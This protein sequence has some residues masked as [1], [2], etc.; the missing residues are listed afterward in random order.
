MCRCPKAVLKWTWFKF[1]L[2][3]DMKQSNYDCFITS[4]C[5]CLSFYLISYFF[6]IFCVTDGK[7]VDDRECI[8][9]Q[10]YLNAFSIKNRFY[11]ELN[12]NKR[13]K[14]KYHSLSLFNYNLRLLIIWN[15]HG[16]ACVNVTSL[17]SRHF[18]KKK[19]IKKTITKK[20]WSQKKTI[21]FYSI[22]YFI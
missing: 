16:G 7:R 2:L 12:V 14:W 10:T 3:L 18:K 15:L 11:Y 1:Y 21:Y 13:I 4:M 6:Y 9:Y 19:Y 20:R 22:F 8:A 5:L 17:S